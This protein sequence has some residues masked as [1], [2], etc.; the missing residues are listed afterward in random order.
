MRPNIFMY[1]QYIY[2]YIHIHIYL[3]THVYRGRER[4][5]EG[6]REIICHVCSG[7][8][9]SPRHEATVQK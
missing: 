3:Y 5:R 8:L 1:T 6:G 2:I 7:Y 4:E 9:P